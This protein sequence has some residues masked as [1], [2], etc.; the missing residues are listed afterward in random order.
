LNGIRSGV[1]RQSQLDALKARSEDTDYVPMSTTRLLTTNA[2]V[3]E[4]NHRHLLK[5]EGDSK[6]FLM[7]TSGPKK[8]VE[9]LKRSC[10]APEVLE[11]KIG[12]A[13]MCIKNSQDKKY[14]NGSLGVVEDF[15]DNTGYPVVK[16]ING[17]LLT[18]KPDTWELLDG[19]KRRAQLTQLPL[20][21]A[22]AITVHKSQGMTLDSA[23]IDLSNAFVEGMG[24][25]ALSRVRGLENLILD[26]LNGMALRVS[27]V[28]RQIDVELRD[29]SQAALDDHGQ[30][31]ID[32]KNTEKKRP[33]VSVKLRPKNVEG[34]GAWTEKLE[35]M[36]EQY[37]NAYMPWKE[38]EDTEL[39]SL[40]DDGKKMD[41]IS[42]KLG[43]HPGSIRSR[44]KKHYGDNF[45]FL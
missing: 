34:H 31:I 44:L 22:W 2:N 28:A 25:V 4:I 1:L 36:R 33:K 38:Q 45:S 21:L 30:L 27:Q 15:D 10:L 5:L 32:W 20:R 18:I 19:D 14:V 42:R 43:R 7:T 24:Y 17:R 35:K 39:K 29:K 37:P 26:G 3:D 41:Y 11:L 23:R 9:Q 6:E 16:L 13:V 8:Y 40:F 12:A